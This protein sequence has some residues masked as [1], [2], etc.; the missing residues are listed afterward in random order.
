MSGPERHHHPGLTLGVAVT[1][2]RDAQRKY[3]CVVGRFFWLSFCFVGGFVVIGD[4]LGS[5]L[6]VLAGFGLGGGV[7][8]G[9][10]GTC[11]GPNGTNSSLD[12]KKRDKTA[13]CRIWR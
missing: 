3:I 1:H 9:L 4:A 6:G 5:R 2:T 11:P 10:G 13:V 7:S 12:C 8:D